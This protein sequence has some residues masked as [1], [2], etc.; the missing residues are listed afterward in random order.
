MKVGIEALKSSLKD[1]CRDSSSSSSFSWSSSPRCP[2][3]AASLSKAPPCTS[4]TPKAE[5]KVLGVGSDRQSAS[6]ER[7]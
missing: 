5:R 4:R 7:G 1:T 6:R 2:R 3:N